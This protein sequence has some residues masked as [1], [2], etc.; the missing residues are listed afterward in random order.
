M[1]LSVK[2]QVTRGELLHQRLPSGTI[3]CHNGSHGHHGQTA[4]VDFL[5]K[6]NNGA[7]PDENPLKL[8]TERNWVICIFKYRYVYPIPIY[9]TNVHDPSETVSIRVII[10]INHTATYC[11]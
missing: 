10:I 5:K 9:I 3:L 7:T 4:V 6:H 8:E 1:V 11:M 2:F